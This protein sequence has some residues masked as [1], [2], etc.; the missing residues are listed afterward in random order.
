VGCWAV[1]DRCRCRSK[2]RQASHAH[3]AIAG[4]AVQ[5]PGLGRRKHHEYGH[6]CV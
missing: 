3:S 5:L 4:R 6:C 1:T 2:H